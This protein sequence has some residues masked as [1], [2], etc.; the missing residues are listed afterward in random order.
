MH[1]A[2][3]LP[4][5]MAPPSGA[6]RMQSSR[7]LE[8]GLLACAWVLSHT[9]ARREQH[10]PDLCRY[11]PPF[12]A[13]RA[14]RHPPLHQAALLLCVTSPYERPR[15][16]SPRRHPCLSCPHFHPPPALVTATSPSTWPWDQLSRAH[17]TTP[18]QL[19]YHCPLAA[20]QQLAYLGSPMRPSDS[21]KPIPPSSCHSVCPSLAA[22]SR[23]RPLRARRGD[24]GLDRVLSAEI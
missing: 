9:R 17:A 8:R 19:P 16:L 13:S 7:R 4:M 1:V 18:P 5:L 15:S 20:C 2:F 21:R 12:P 11:T 22:S 14:G 6:Q 23:H 10:P 24:R 3:Q